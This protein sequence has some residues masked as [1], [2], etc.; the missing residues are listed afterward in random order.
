MILIVGG[1]GYIGSHTNKLLSKQGHETVVFDNLVHGH[2]EFVKW[3]SF[4]HGDLSNKE[5]IMQCFLKYPIHA[6]MHFSAFAYIGESVCEPGKY[7]KNNVSNTVNLLEIMRKFAVNKIVFSSSCSIYGEPEEIPITETHPKYPTNPYGKSKLMVEE[8]LKDYDYAHGIKHISLRYF[9]AA[10]ADPELEIGEKH[11]PETHLI[12]LIMQ[13]ASG[14]YP[15]ITIYGDAYPTPDGT[16]I[17]DYIHVNDIAK[18]HILALQALE[19][20]MNSTA[21]NLG[22]GN[23]YSVKEIITLSEQ[24]TG[25]T[26]KRKMGP[27]RIGDPAQL[28]SDSRKAKQE[29][30]WEPGYADIKIIVE[31]AWN[32]HL[33]MLSGFRSPYFNTQIQR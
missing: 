23:A 29:L 4:F 30:G 17:R 28:I 11:N 14:L 31:H 8:I 10:G 1:A 3:G 26:I 6:V 13:V 5:Q 15:H 9:N 19:S 20:G 21:M 12:P 32:W 24:V 33:K 16:C 2:R 18:A 22:N 25:G 7:Y 27:K